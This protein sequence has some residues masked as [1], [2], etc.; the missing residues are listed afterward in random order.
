MLE[1]K[2]LTED[3]FKKLLNN[4]YKDGARY[5]YRPTGYGLVYASPSKPEIHSDGDIT[6]LTGDSKALR[7]DIFSLLCDIFDNTNCIDIGKVL[8]KVDWSKVPV[9]ARVC[10]YKDGSMKLR[11]F[12]SYKD[13]KVYTWSDGGTSWSVPYMYGEWDD[14]RLVEDI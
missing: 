7:Y 11:H 8:N 13:G 5:L 9:D 3:G 10:A 14:V 12:A 2:Y 4:L 6:N 1:S